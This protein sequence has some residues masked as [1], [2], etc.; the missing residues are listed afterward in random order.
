MQMGAASGV[1]D[2]ATLPYNLL[3]IAG[4]CYHV[5]VAGFTLHGGNGW[6]SMWH[7]AAADFVQ[8]LDVITVG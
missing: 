3:P 7:G 4:T 8:S 5:G 2:A 6:A 1:V